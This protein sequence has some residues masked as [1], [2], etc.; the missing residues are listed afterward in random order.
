MVCGI[1]SGK[2]H[3]AVQ[4]A[5]IAGF[6]QSG[7]EAGLTAPT[8]SIFRRTFLPVWRRLVPSAMYR[9]K[10]A[11]QQLVLANGTTIHCM[12][13]KDSQNRVLG[14]SW[15]WAIM[16]EAG[17]ERDPDAASRLMERVRGGNELE[18]FLLLLTS[19]HG[20]GWLSDFLG[21]P[22][23]KHINATTYDNPFLPASYIRDLE[24]QYPKGTPVHDQQMLGKLIHLLGLLYGHFFVRSKHVVPL[25]HDFTAPYVLGWDPGKRAS[26]VVA[27]QALLPDHLVIVKQWTPRDEPTEV[28][29]VKVKQEMGRSPTHIYMD[30]PSKHNT[31]SGLGDVKVLRAVFG[32][33]C[34]VKPL[35]GIVRSSDY[36][37]DAVRTGL[38][39]QRLLISASLVHKRVAKD[40]SG[41]V[42]ALE[43]MPYERAEPANETVKKTD[44]RKHILDAL[45]F[46]MVKAMPPRYST[47][48]DRFE[49]LERLRMR[50]AA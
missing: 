11:D 24:D 34:A 23:V 28:T 42:H 47:A 10:V 35:G 31:R 18:R 7:V 21:L 46:A 39:Q 15:A 5:K 44:P 8:F 41:I 50:D 3:G 2:T 30:T 17:A 1:G 22:R 29:A 45:E 14:D 19:P 6:S 26:G 38:V 37:H 43:T 4:L 40:E 48:P 13:T 36:R 32:G 25:E 16:D 33:R 27:L 49:E 12:G 20:H 9:W